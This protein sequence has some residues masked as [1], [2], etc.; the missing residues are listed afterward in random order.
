MIGSGGGQVGLADGSAQVVFPPGAVS[1][2][3]TVQIARTAAPP[4]PA[5][6]QLV[7]SPVALTATAPDGT[8]I[9]QFSQPVQITL[10][11]G[12]TTPP[13][14][15]FFFDGSRWQELSNSVVNQANHSVTAPSAHFTV[16][17]A[18]T[19]VP[20]LAITGFSVAQFGPQLARP[21][22]VTPTASVTPSG[23]PTISTSWSPTS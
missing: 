7:S 22:T 2:S 1:D 19:G 11:F 5:G 23:T 4:L 10:S 6:Q 18:L 12:G 15:I 3:T 17:G 21:L 16:F 8:P 14:G 20:E 9:T 13:A